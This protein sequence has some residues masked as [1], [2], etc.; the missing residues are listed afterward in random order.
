MEWM[1][2]HLWAVWV[3]L[4]A[5]LIIAE[6]VSL[7]LVLLMLAIGALAGAATSLP[8]DSW[9]VQTLVAAG[10][11]LALLA[12]VRPTLVRR[13]HS[14]PDLLVGPQRV[15]GQQALTT[16]AL[17]VTAPGR[18]KIDGE[19]WSAR[20]AY[21]APSIAPGQQIVVLEIDGATAVVAP[22]S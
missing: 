10:V 17:S 1:G 12:V 9:I 7:D 11:S 20:P 13:L 3:A 22:I 14:G 19:F 15:L 6:V 21:G 5:L 4:A 16:V 18:V 2:D 8:T